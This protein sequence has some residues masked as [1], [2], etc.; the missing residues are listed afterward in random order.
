V[1]KKK[2]ATRGNGKTK[3]SPSNKA[4]SAAH[5]RGKKEV[6]SHPMGKQKDA[7]QLPKEEGAPS[8]RGKKS[9]AVEK[10]PLKASTVP[11]GCGERSVR[12]R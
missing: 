9:H 8:P 2:L 4:T 1:A 12:D 11:G 10:K 5:P 7:T 3:A 6:R